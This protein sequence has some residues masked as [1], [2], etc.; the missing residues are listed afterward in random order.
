ML[1]TTPGLGDHI[2]GAILYDETCASRPRPAAVRQV[3]LDAGVLPGI[4]VDLGT[5][6]RWPASRASWSPRAWTAC[7]SA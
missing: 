5:V 6:R 7:A 4:K 3:M 1:L 2:S